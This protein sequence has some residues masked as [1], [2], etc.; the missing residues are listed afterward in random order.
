MIRAALALAFLIACLACVHAP[1]AQAPTPPP[2]VEPP[3]PPP[4]PTVTARQ[5]SIPGSTLPKNCGLVERSDVSSVVKE[6]YYAALLICLSKPEG[7]AEV[8]KSVEPVK[9]PAK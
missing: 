8:K 2:A 6:P 4:K 9:G 1:V 7:I 5:V 3:A